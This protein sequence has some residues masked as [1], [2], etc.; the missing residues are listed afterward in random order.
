ME[1]KQCV[2][3][4]LRFKFSVGFVVTNRFQFSL[5]CFIFIVS[6]FILQFVINALFVKKF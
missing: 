4:K 6:F 1:I 5:V 2:D 3:L